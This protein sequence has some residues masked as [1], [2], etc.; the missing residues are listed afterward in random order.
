MME[1]IRNNYG[2]TVNVR[3]MVIRSLFFIYLICP[4]AGS[5]FDLQSNTPSITCYHQSDG[6]V[7]GVTTNGSSVTAAVQFYQEANTAWTIVGQGD[8]DGDGIRDL[9]W[10]NN[11]TGQ[12]YLM[13]M[14][15]PTTMKSGA[16]AYTEPDTNWRV[17]T[18]G[19]IDGDGR[20]DLIWWN[21]T[22]GQVYAMLMNGTAA[23]GGAI[24]YTE[25][26]TA[27][28]IV[29]AADF[30]GNGTVELLWWNTSTG[31]AALGQTSGTGASNASV[32]WTEPNTDWRIAGAGDLDA[33]GRADIVWHNR[34]TGQVYGMQTNGSS[35][36]NGAIMYTEPN[37]QWEIVSLGDYNDD[38]R[39][40]LLWWNQQTGQVYLMLMNGLSVAG[41]SLLYTEPDVTWK[42]Q[43]ETEW[44]DHVYG[45]GITTTTSVSSV[46][47][48]AA[49]TQ[50]SFRSL[51]PSEPRHVNR[52]VVSPAGRI[53][54]AWYTQSFLAYMSYSD[55][56]GST[57]KHNALERMTQIHQLIR[58]SDGTLVAGGGISRYRSPALVQ[59]RR[60]NDLEVR[61]NRN[62]QHDRS[63]ERT[64]VHNL[65]SG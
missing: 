43:G 29:A 5:A 10:W 54:A 22:T 48:T 3:S 64:I 58:M 18:T 28:K 56:N 35:V 34:K 55:D 12:L 21:G 6:I 23:T 62:K 24:I 17:V 14:A 45:R 59:Q 4:T 2:R 50:T 20:S 16:I 44:R 11:S 36:T 8:F 26:N 9:V 51:A 39:A 42:I 49:W 37:M 25:P 38:G 33:D 63:A 57:W 19:D 47:N 30:N 53:H 27:W 15:G 61:R 40:D 60:W 7:S 52:V 41:G 13:L 65:G 32:I 1:C 46:S 31:Q